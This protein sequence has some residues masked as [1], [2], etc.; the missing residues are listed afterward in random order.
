MRGRYSQRGSH[1]RPLRARRSSLLTRIFALYHL[2]S[3]DSFF[4]HR[5]YTLYML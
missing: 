5:T 3:V 4:L 2:I 1:I